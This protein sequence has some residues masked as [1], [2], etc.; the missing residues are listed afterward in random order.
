MSARLQ[1]MPKDELRRVLERADV[2]HDL[3]NE[4]LNQLPDRSWALSNSE[5]CA[6]GGPERSWVTWSGGL[7]REAVTV[8]R[9]GRGCR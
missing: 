7:A 6:V 3:I 1:T 5:H 2:P 9:H 4:T 8:F